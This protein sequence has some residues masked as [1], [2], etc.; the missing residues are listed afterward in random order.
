M[1]RCIIAF[2]F[3]LIG[4]FSQ[5]PV[6]GSDGGSKLAMVLLEQSQ[7]SQGLAHQYA[8]FVAG[9]LLASES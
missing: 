2:M 6:F 1:V 8:C 3:V 5:N 7:G 4:S 9:S